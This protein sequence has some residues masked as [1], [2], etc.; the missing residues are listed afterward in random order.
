MAALSTSTAEL[1]TEIA[2]SP[3]DA[4][5]RWSTGKA[6]R[7][8][9]I[10]GRPVGTSTTHRRTEAAMKEPQDPRTSEGEDHLDEQSE[11]VSAPHR[12]DDP[13][14]RDA[15]APVTSALMLA[16]WIALGVALVVL[17]IVVLV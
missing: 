2:G 1:T 6:L 4:G 17:A 5:G 14:V 7:A 9:R 3:V 12:D 10:P 15:R 8:A 11:T 13:P 16:L